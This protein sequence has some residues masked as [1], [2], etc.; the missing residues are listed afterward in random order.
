M[1]KCYSNVVLHPS[2]TH[3]FAIANLNADQF[4]DCVLMIC[5]FVKALIFIDTLLINPKD[6]DGL[7]NNED[8][9]QADPLRVKEQSDQGHSMPVFLNI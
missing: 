6:A 4:Y 1:T 8:P 5:S 2:W 3:H 9:D 7:I